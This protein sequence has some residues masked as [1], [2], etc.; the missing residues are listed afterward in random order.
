MYLTRR[1]NVNLI[2]I[3]QN[4]FTRININ[5]LILFPDLL[6]FDPHIPEN[7]L[8][9]FSDHLH[10]DFLRLIAG[11]KL[12]NGKEIV[13]ALLKVGVADREG[14]LCEVLVIDKVLTKGFE[15]EGCFAGDPHSVGYLAD[16]L[17]SM[18]L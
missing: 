14:L 1:S 13:F 9:L 18:R 12:E 3:D 5:R 6:D 7:K 2:L 10:T 4:S 15:F 8:L 17:D 16:C 11:V